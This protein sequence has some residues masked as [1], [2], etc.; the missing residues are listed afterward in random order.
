M[1]VYLKE[2]NLEE[3]TDFVEEGRYPSKPLEAQKEKSIS[4]SVW[5]LVMFI[6]LIN[7]G[8]ML[9]ILDLSLFNQDFY[10]IT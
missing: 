4:K 7:C 10:R 3:N 2:K 9:I 6:A 1:F 5:S 8:T